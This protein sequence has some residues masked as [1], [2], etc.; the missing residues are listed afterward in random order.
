MSPQAGDE[1]TWTFQG[2]TDN[3]AWVTLSGTVL[4]AN[5]W[6]TQPTTNYFGGFATNVAYPTDSSACQG[7][8]PGPVST[9]AEFMVGPPAAPPSHPPA[10]AGNLGARTDENGAQVVASP[11]RS[12]VRHAVPNLRMTDDTG[13]VRVAA[14]TLNPPLGPPTDLATTRCRMK[15]GAARRDADSGS[16]TTPLEPCNPA[17][18]DARGSS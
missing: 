2:S 12:R 9:R 13:A 15:P 16:L 11:G 7:I 17:R 3:A 10:S 8:A 6:F 4:L 18:T 14:I 1:G 5:A